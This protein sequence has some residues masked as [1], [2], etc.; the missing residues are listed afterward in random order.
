MLALIT[1]NVTFSSTSQKTIT[2]L[3]RENFAGY[4]GNTSSINIKIKTFL[5]VSVV[6]YSMIMRGT[7]RDPNFVTVF[8]I[9]QFLLK[10]SYPGSSTHW[11][12]IKKFNVMLMM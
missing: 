5:S 8:I 1:L 6:S 3:K 9:R 2:N 7:S 12:V 4:C 11:S 10:N